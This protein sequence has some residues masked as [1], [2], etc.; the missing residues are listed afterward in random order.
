MESQDDESEEESSSDDDYR[1]DD[2]IDDESSDDYEADYDD[3]DDDESGDDD[4]EEDDGGYDD[5]KGCTAIIGYTGDKGSEEGYD[6]HDH[7]SS[8]GEE[9]TGEELSVTDTHP[10]PRRKRGDK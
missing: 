8:H 5:G 7:D 4:G 2:D 9:R 6:S 10:P 3:A 1:S